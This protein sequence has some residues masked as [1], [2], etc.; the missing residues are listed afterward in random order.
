[1]I[2]FRCAS[3][4]NTRPAGQVGDVKMGK[5][6][7]TPGSYSP[8]QPDVIELRCAPNNS[9]YDY[10]YPLGDA[11]SSRAISS[12]TRGNPCRGRILEALIAG[13]ATSGA[14]EPIA[15]DIC[16]DQSHS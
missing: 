14:P 8:K 4:L 13:F 2:L 5:S 11:A 12:C 7:H 1:M 15:I 16:K 6:A 9:S 3:G 10:Q